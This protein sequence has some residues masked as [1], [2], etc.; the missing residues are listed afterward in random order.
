MRNCKHFQVR[1][2]LNIR[3]SIGQWYLVLLKLFFIQSITCALQLPFVSCYLPGWLSVV[4]TVS[5]PTSVYHMYQSVFL[6]CN[7]IAKAD[8]LYKENRFIQLTVLR[9]ENLI[10]IVLVLARNCGRQQD[11]EHV[12]EE[13]SHCGTES[14][15][16][17]VPPEDAPTE[18]RTVF[19][20]PPLNSS[21]PLLPH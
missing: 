2:P 19:Q 14:E 21:I 11:Q 7:Q 12:L 13:R 4:H 3:F 5:I 18:T 1:H 17:A 16:A 8:Y 20:F 15:R 10:S 6:Y 9:V